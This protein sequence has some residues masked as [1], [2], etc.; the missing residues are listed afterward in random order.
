MSA[1]AQQPTDPKLA[2]ETCALVSQQRNA[3]MDALAGSEARRKIDGEDAAKLKQ[4]VEQWEAYFRAYTGEA[5][6]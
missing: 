3:V 1:A 5:K 6:S 4:R 2:G